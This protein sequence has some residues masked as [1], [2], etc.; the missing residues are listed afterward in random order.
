MN[1]IYVCGHRNPDTDSIV[2]SMAYANLRN[3][4]G[5]R[6]YKA[7][8]IGAINDETQKLLDRF[9]YPAPPLVKNMR[10]QVR[11][12]DFDHPPALDRSVTLE[13]LRT[14]HVT[15]RHYRNRRI[16]EFLKE[17]HLTEG[18]NTGFRKILRALEHNGSP[19]PE[20][21]TDE[22]RSFF[23]TRL[24]RHPAFAEVADRETVGESSD[25]GRISD[26]IS[27]KVAEHRQRVMELLSLRGH[28]QTN[29]IAEELGIKP[30]RTRQLLAQMATDGLIE[31]HGER[32]GRYYCLPDSPESRDVPC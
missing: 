6:E 24:H 14:F 29:E 7:V 8:R 21:E 30:P 10:T 13:G 18:R 15:N 16:G 1:D 31:A 3:A 20:F 17:I 2:A 19:L 23:I 32:R 4:L 12:L 25:K 9:D 22:E 27:D 28:A 5:D 11:D 26:K